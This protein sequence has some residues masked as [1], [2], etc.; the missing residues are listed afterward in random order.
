[1]EDEI[2]VHSLRQAQEIF[3]VG[4]PSTIQQWCQTGRLDGTF[5]DKRWTIRIPADHPDLPKNKVRADPIHH[6]R[7]E[8]VDERDARIATLEAELD[9]VRSERDFLREQQL[10]WQRTLPDLVARLVAGLQPPALPPPPESPPRRWWR[11]LSKL[12]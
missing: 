5:E 10:A 4:S 1:M 9:A 2:V 12:Y 11:W 8:V 3:K 7:I 6:P